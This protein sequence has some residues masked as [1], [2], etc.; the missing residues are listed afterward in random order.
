MIEWDF[1]EDEESEGWIEKK[2]SH[3]SHSVPCTVRVH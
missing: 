1:S 3:I 2:G